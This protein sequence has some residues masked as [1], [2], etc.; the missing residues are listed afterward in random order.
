[1]NG[2]GAQT[3]TTRVKLGA[4]FGLS[5]MLDLLMGMPRDLGV[6]ATSKD[7]SRI[8][9]IGWNVIPTK[10][11]RSIS[12]E[13]DK[14]LDESYGSSEL[15]AVVRELEGYKYMPFSGTQIRL[16]KENIEIS[17][18]VRLAGLARFAEEMQLNADYFRF[19]RNAAELAGLFVSNPPFY[20]C[21][22]VYAQNQRVGVDIKHAELGPLPVPVAGSD[23]GRIVES[24]FMMCGL[25]AEEARI[26]GS[27]MY[28]KGMIPENIYIEPR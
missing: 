26:N 17:G 2:F 9:E 19:I 27:R 7:Y 1:L 12:F 11:G 18:R 14:I 23:L 13:G 20:L 28:I 24:I 15:T 22:S 8:H 25:Q 4:R 3:D 21:G 10:N 16:G 6:R 5:K